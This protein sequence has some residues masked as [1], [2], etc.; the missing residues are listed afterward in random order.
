MRSFYL[1][2]PQLRT[3]ILPSAFGEFPPLGSV[4]GSKRDFV[5]TDDEIRRLEFAVWQK[6]RV[7]ESPISKAPC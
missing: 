6:D 2:L 1:A 7:I 5:I 3:R 4:F